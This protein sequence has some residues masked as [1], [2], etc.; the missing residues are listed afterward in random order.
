M[1]MGTSQLG[2]AGPNL[3]TNKPRPII[4]LAALNGY[5]VTVG[6]QHL[7][8][9]DRNKMLAKIDRYLE[10]PQAVEKEYLDRYGQ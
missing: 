8:F 5:Q 10:F 7:V 2:E 1:E 6:C 9:E 3:A 4:V